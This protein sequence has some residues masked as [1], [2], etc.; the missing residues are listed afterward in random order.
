M[1]QGDGLGVKALSLYKCE[2]CTLL[3]SEPTE[4]SGGSHPI[5]PAS[6]VSTGGL[7]S[8]LAWKTSWV[9]K[10]WTGQRGPVSESK[11]EE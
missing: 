2:D 4:I 9:A 11:T 6:E 10:L 8:A 7:W 1:S 5:V 3:S